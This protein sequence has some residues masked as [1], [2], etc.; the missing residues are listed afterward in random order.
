MVPETSESAMPRL[1]EERIL[2]IPD[3][4]QN[5]SWLLAVLKKEAQTSNAI[6]LLGDYFDP[7]VEQASSTAATAEIIA[8]LYRN[9]SVPTYLLAG[10]HDLP[11]LFDLHYLMR[12]L[13]PPENPYATAA[14]RRS[15]LP[16]ILE[17]WP[18][19]LLSGLLPFVL[20]NGYLLSHAGLKQAHWPDGEAVNEASL[21]KLYRRLQ[22]K[23]HDLRGEPDV[24][25]S[26][27]PASRGGLDP[28]GGITWQDWEEDFV[29]DL[30]WPQIVGHTLLD[31]PREKGRS[32]NVDACGSYYA[33]LR[34]RQIILRKL[35]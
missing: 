1:H 28:I 24:M 13:R 17:L 20:A 30:P 16:K 31:K 32:W 11:Y 26:G 27:V 19:D 33:L 35:R 8:D 29:D 4:H 6:V 22:G 10:N 21:A 23:L 9:Q 2:V 34:N 7:K 25:L 18:E 15:A 5:V 14:Y 12:G 3:L